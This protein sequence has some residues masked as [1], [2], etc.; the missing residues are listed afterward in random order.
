MRECLSFDDILMEPRYS[1]LI[2]RQDIDLSVEL[3]NGLRL[4]FPLIASP[5]DTISEKYMAF[6]MANFG[7]AAVIHRYNTIQEQADIISEVR[8][9][10]GAA[11]GVTDDFIERAVAS[12]NSGANF[13]CVDVAHGHHALVKRGLTLL[14]KTLGADVHIMAGN[15]ATLQGITDLASWG[16]NSVR[17]GIGGGA[18]CSTRIQTGHGMPTLQSVFDCAAIESEV[19][20]IAD[21]GIKTSGDI[22]K[23]LAAGADAV[24]CGSLIAGTDETPGDVFGN[25]DGTRWK[26]YRGMASKESQVKWKGKYSSFEGVSSRIPYRGPVTP[27]LKDLERGIRS[28]L[29]YSGAKSIEELQNSARFIRQTSAGIY[30]SSTHI[31]TRKW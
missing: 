8:G 10:V 16:A 15:V 27:I 4:D 14:R 24:M 9:T 2:S 26:I 7:G 19:T 25:P 3:G 12:L 20:I 18:I 5:M 30:E 23:S 29:S 11:I 6:A 28:G 22:V 1:E 13:L 31:Q 21:G 17:V